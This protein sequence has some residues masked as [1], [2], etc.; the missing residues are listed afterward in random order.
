MT[1]AAV[2]WCVVA[3][4]F[5]LAVFCILVRMGIEAYDNTK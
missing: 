2:L 3:V 4:I 1:G 5:G